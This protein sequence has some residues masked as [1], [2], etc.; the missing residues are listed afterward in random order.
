MKDSHFRS[1][2]LDHYRAFRSIQLDGFREVNIIGGVNG[3]GKTT[4]LEGAFH[5]LD[6]MNPTTLFRPTQW[7]QVPFEPA[8][9]LDIIKQC[10]YARD[11]SKRIKIVGCQKA[12]DLSLDFAFGNVSMAP[13]AVTNVTQGELNRVSAETSFAPTGEG[14]TVT[15][16]RLQRRDLEYKLSAAGAG[17]II[18]FVYQEQLPVPVAV[19]LNAST[20]STDYVG[21]AT[22][23]SNLVRNGRERYLDDLLRLVHPEVSEIKLLSAGQVSTI[24][25]NIGSG[26]WVPLSFL[27]EGSVSLASM[28]IAMADSQGGII[29]LDEVDATVHHSALASMWRLIMQAAIDFDVQVFATTHSEESLEA[30]AEAASSAARLDKLSYT[31]L[32]KTKSGDLRGVHYD[33]ESLVSAI[34]QDWDVR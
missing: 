17:L 31:R 15:G 33:G 5:V 12:S 22:R 18:Q 32:R 4:L 30:V 14:L 8:D 27:G 23:Y 19:F 1:I 10:F 28:I 20:R 11:T 25:A 2:R 6:R 3:S 24:A 16:K 7:R 13:G 26:N 29:F 9:N 34:K 21:M